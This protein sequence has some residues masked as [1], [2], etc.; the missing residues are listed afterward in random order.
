MVVRLITNG[1]WTFVIGILDSVH[2][3]IGLTHS[4]LCYNGC[5][6]IPTGETN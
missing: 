4:F 1:G 6:V 5:D 3:R 2:L